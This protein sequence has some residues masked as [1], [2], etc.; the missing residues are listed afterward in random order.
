MMADTKVPAIIF[1]QLWRF[2]AVRADN[3]QISVPFFSEDSVF[4]PGSQI[5]H[6]KIVTQQ[7]K[8]SKTVAIFRNCV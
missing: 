1:M 4:R 7:K 5:F 2:T 3:A 6:G 8:L